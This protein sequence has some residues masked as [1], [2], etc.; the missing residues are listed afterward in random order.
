MLAPV[1]FCMRLNLGGLLNSQ[2]WSSVKRL[3]R[4]FVY[5]IVKR[6]KVLFSSG[7][8]LCIVFDYK[9]S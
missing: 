3:V 7:N 4:H 9:K 1:L 6:I 5:D 2:Q 8:N